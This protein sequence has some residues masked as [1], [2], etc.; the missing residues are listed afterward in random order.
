MQRKIS[1]TRGTDNTSVEAYLVDLGQRHVDDYVNDWVE[2]LRLFTQE[3]KYW[4]WMFKLRYIANQ[5]NLEGYAVECENTTQG[6]MII[7]TQMHGSRLNIGKRLVYVETPPLVGGFLTQHSALFILM[8]VMQKC[9]ITTILTPRC[10]LY[11]CG[12]GF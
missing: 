11:S 2:K 4:D 6:L 8:L 1:L 7:E 5:A 9:N 3:D 10:S 12:H